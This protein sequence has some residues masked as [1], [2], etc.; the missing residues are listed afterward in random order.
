MSLDQQ[1]YSRQL[2]SAPPSWSRLMCAW[3]FAYPNF[4][5]SYVPSHFLLWC[6]CTKPRQHPKYQGSWGQHGAHL[7]PVGP[8]WASC[9]PHEPCYRDGTLPLWPHR[10]RP[11]DELLVRIPTT[12]WDH[13]TFHTSWH[14][15]IYIYIYILHISQ[16]SASNCREYQLF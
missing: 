3:K 11:W 13:T 4:P 6:S 1:L 10:P 5:T 14:I 8:R 2:S 9:W 12:K 7:G 15:Y 16:I